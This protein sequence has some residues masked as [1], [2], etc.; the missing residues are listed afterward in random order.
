MGKSIFGFESVTPKNSTVDVGRVL[1]RGV[2]LNGR[3]IEVTNPPGL[4]E[5]LD[6]AYTMGK[7]EGISE[8]C[9][10]LRKE[11]RLIEGTKK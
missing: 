6:D 11:L 7:L 8:T 9:A 3:A 10:M 5:L 4:V 1:I 2:V